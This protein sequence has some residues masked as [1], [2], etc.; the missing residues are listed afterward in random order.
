MA[1]YCTRSSIFCNEDQHLKKCHL[2]FLGGLHNEARASG[3]NLHY[4]FK[5]SVSSLFHRGKRRDA[6]MKHHHITVLIN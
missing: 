4:G 2:R 1:N 5:D 3:K 6:I